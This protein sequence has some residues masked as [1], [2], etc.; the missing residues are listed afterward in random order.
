LTDNI[1]KALGRLT[2][3]SRRL[4][5][6][7]FSA[8]GAFWT[9]L[10]LFCFLV[11][12]A[13]PKIERMEDWTSRDFW[14]DEYLEILV[15]L[16]CAGYIKIRGVYK[17]KRTMKSSER[18]A[19][20]SRRARVAGLVEELGAVKSKEECVARETR[21]IRESILTAVSLSSIEFL[22]IHPDETLSVSLVD[23]YG[24]SLS[25]V[26]SKSMMVTA[27]SMGDGQVRHTRR[28]GD[29]LAYESV[30]E[31]AYKIVDDIRK[32]NRWSGRK[33]SYR[34]IM[35]IPITRGDAK[36]GALCIKYTKPYGFVRRSVDVNSL[37]Q[38]Y[39]SLLALTYPEVDLSSPCEHHHGH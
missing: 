36:F 30:A 32:D 27:R 5:T 24:M 21:R 17:A 12:I 38:P 18:D 25:G 31:M 10:M 37:V 14:N 11:V 26:D 1:D 4:L 20:T 13:A 39:V 16:L 7:D 15:V 33:C 3:G 9:S 29:L 19:W 8:R 22:K 2:T 34:T 23:F 28:K 6:K 35:T